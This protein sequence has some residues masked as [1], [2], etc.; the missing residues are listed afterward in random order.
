MR[1]IVDDSDD[2]GAEIVSMNEVDEKTGNDG[3]EKTVEPPYH[4]GDHNA[5]IAGTSSE[6]T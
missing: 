6:G 1:R 3:S 2:E 4:R 5:R